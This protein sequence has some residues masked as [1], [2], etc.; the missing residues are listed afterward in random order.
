MY[1]KVSFNFIIPVLTSIHICSLYRHQKKKTIEKLCELNPDIEN[2]KE[3]LQDLKKTRQLASEKE[4][5][6]SIILNKLDV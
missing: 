3:L 6:V 1:T 4:G 5:E 2:A